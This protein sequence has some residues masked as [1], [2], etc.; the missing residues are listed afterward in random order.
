[1]GLWFFSSIPMYISSRFPKI[2]IFFS[3][4]LTFFKQLWTC[5][6]NFLSPHLNSADFSL[7]SHCPI[8]IKFGI[9]TCSSHQC[10]WIFSLVFLKFQFFSEKTFIFETTLLWDV[11]RG[12]E[13]RILFFIYELFKFITE[14]GASFFIAE[15][16]WCGI[17]WKSAIVLIDSE[18][19]YFVIAYYQTFF[20][21]ENDFYYK[22]KNIYIFFKSPPTF[23]K[24]LG[25]TFLTQ[26]QTI[27][28]KLILFKKK[29]K[30]IHP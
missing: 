7:L 6:K 20:A 12:D 28:V 14:R 21:Y 24:T 30:I 1:M 19:W 17:V 2:S 29:K 23:L 22:F 5:K 25:Q 16:F 26:S 10:P 11:F 18:L 27:S 3:G 13:G 4:K 9:A 15:G 8:G